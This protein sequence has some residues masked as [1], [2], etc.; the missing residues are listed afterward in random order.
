MSKTIALFGGSF[1][2]PHEGHFTMASYIHQT[3]AVDETW[4]MF[5]QNPEKDPAAYP[6]LEHRMNMARI[7]AKHYSAP[8]VISDEEAKIAKEIGRNESYFILQGLKQKYPDDKFIFV[9]GADSF[10]KFHQWVEQDDI[11]QEH[12]VAVVDR[13]GYTLQAL[14][15]PTAIA[16]RNSMIDITD[17]DNL[18]N[19]NC[20]WCFLNN[21]QVDISSSGILKQ[22]SEGKTL[23]DGHFAEVAEYIYQHGLYNIAKSPV[24]EFRP[25]QR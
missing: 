13:P 16:F 8:I 2:P 21:P 20:G 25:I 14:N 5:S 17:P 12:I 7:L 19:A 22:F 24:P 15:G 3:L 1:N 6:P 9:M 10:A 18:K 11:L 23:F 4:M